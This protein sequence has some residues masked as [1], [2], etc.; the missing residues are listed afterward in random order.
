MTVDVQKSTTEA[1]I[2]LRP[3]HM[4][5]PVSFLFTLYKSA[6][7]HSQI[8]IFTEILIIRSALFRNAQ[9]GTG[10]LLADVPVPA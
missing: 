6:I 2:A 4:K 1:A 5:Y 9:T 8:W 10:T 7:Y 3:V